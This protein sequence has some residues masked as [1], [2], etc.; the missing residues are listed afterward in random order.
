MKLTEL[1]KAILAF[2]GMYSDEYDFI[3]AQLDEEKEYATVNGKRLALPTEQQLRNPNNEKIIFHP[4][5]EDIMTGISD[6]LSKYRDVLNIRLNYSIGMV[7]QYLLVLAASPELHRELT[8]TQIK[9]LTLIKDADDITVKNFTSI[10]VAGIK[11]KP[12]RVFTN[13]VVMR[14]G[15]V[16]DARFKRTGNVSFP[17]LRELENEAP[18]GVKL[19][20]KD[21][22]VLKGVFE[23]IFRTINESESYSRGSMDQIAPFVHALMLSG[24]AVASDINDTIEVFKDFIDG[25]EKLM[26]DMSWFST[27]SNLEGFVKEIRSVPPQPGNEGKSPLGTQLSNQAPATPVQAPVVTPV[28]PTTVTATPVQQPV[29]LP[30]AQQ[31]TPSLPWNP[32]PQMQPQAPM[33]MPVPNPMMQPTMQQP[34]MQQAPVPQQPKVTGGKLDFQSLKQARPGLGMGPNPLQ[35]QIVNQ[36]VQQMVNQGVNPAMITGMMQ[37]NMGQFPMQQERVP[38]WAQPQ[39]PQM[40]PNMMPGMMPMNNNMMMQGNMNQYPMQN[41]YMQQQPMNSNVLIQGTMMQ[42]PLYRNF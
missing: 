38:G 5:H 33:Q 6:V 26:F 40:Q 7:A 9:L 2:A 20:K 4:L 19:R 41:Q 16:K 29:P 28:V 1:Y 12:D 15:T 35:A 30:T 22:P 23:L 25:S 17:I 34:M 14:N 37:G 42:Q 31:P 36:Q 24:A 8:P 3:Y 18:Y 11:Q 39:M 32:T 21:K 10:M 13:V 27:F